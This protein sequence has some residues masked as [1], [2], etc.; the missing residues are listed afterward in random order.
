M[1]KARKASKKP[2]PVRLNLGG[3]EVELP[4][5]VNVDRRVG[6]EAYPLAYADESVDEIRASHLLEHFPHAMTIAVLQDWARTLKPGGIMRIAVPDIDR[7]FDAYHD[8]ASAVPVEGYLMGGQ[9]DQNDVHLAIFN[10]RKLWGAMRAAD[11]IDIQ[12]WVSTVQDCSALPISLNRQAR[13]R[14]PSVER[15][16]AKMPKV[17]AAMSVPR[18]GFMANYFAAYQACLPL[19]IELKM[20]EG[21]YWH[22]AMEECIEELVEAP[23]PPDL[24]MTVDYDSVFSLDNVQGLIQIMQDHPEIDALCPVQMRRNNDYPLMTMQGS[25]EH[26]TSNHATWEDF[27]PLTT[28]IRTGHFGLTMI[29]TASLL[30]VPH[31]WFLPVPNKEGKWKE[32]RID[33]DVN[34]WKTWEK[35]GKS[36][37]LASHIVIGHCELMVSWPGTNLKPF[38]QNIEDYNLSGQPAGVWE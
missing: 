6:T 12:P 32:N 14:P 3:G 36:L 34:F 1:A 33:A 29:R 25:T 27:E 26:G 10:R 11:L 37:H 20:I 13:K 35:H 31:P 9:T 23:K 22:Q 17:S 19:H 38:H 28:P 5:Y 2:E 7:I 30:T 15:S 21:A 4:G 16:D 18:L 8:P 24:V